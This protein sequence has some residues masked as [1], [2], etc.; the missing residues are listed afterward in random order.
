VDLTVVDEAAEAALAAGNA[1]VYLVDEIGKMECLSPRFVEAMRALLASAATVVAT[2]ARRG[3]GFIAEVKQRK[4][5]ELWEV[6][7]ANRD[8][9]PA[10][11]LAWIGRAEA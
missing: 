5:A 10:R 9:L 8:E 1:D 3:Q 2:V 6:T 11:A 4:G 7:R